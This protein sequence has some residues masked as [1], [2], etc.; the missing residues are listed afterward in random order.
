MTLNM[1]ISNEALRVTTEVTIDHLE[2]GRLFGK[3][4]SEQQA[5]F[6]TGM[7][8]GIEEIGPTYGEQLH[9]IVESAGKDDKI[10]DLEDLTVLFVDYFLDRE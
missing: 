2:L 8:I 3:W 6:L 5:N 7:L 4:D 1:E 9:Y 10:K